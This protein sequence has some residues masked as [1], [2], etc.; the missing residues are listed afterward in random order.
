MNNYSTA[1]SDILVII[2]MHRSGSSLTASLL[3][4]AGL[5]IGRKLLGPHSANIKGYFENIDFF[6]FHKAVLR[7]QAII[8]DGWTLQGKINVED[9]FVE[10]AKEI[11]AKNSMSRVWGWKEPRTT[12]FLDFWSDLLPEAKFLLIYRSPW[13]VVDSLYRRGDRTFQDQPELALKV[14]HQYNQIIIDFYD[15]FS[16]RCLLANIN[17]IVNFKDSYIKAINQKFKTNL[18][19]PESTVYDPSLFHAQPLDSYRPSLVN[20][21]CPEAVEMYQELDARAWWPDETPNFS[22]RELIKPVYKAEAFQEWVNT[23]NQERENKALRVQLENF[24]SQLHQTQGELENSQT[25]LNQIQGELESSQTQLHQTQGEFTYSKSQLHQT[26]TQ[27]HQTQGELH[28]T[29]VEFKRSQSQLH[30]TQRE[31]ENSQTQLH[32]TQTELENSQTQLHQTQEEFAYLKSQLHQTQGE[33]HQTQG[34]LHQ[35]QVE[36][37]RSQSQLHQTQGELE[38]SQTQLHQ[39]QTE[40]ENSQTQLHQ[41]QAELENSQTQLHQTQTELKRSQ[42]QLDQT[43]EE[44]AQSHSQVYQSQR[45]LEHSQIQLHETE[46]LLEHSQMQLHQSEALLEQSQTQLHQKQEEWNRLQTQL[47]QI[48][49]KLEQSQTQQHQIEAKVQQFQMQ[50]HQTQEQ[51]QQSQTQLHQTQE[52]LQQ[53]QTQLHQT[54]EQLQ[55]SQTQLHQTQG[56]LE[57]S[58]F[59]QALGNDKDGQYQMQYRLLVWEA[60]RAYHNNALTKMQECLQ[61]SLKYTPFSGTQTVNDWLE[62]LAKFSSEKGCEFDIYSLTNSQEW[63]QLMGRSVRVKPILGRSRFVGQA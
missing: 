31:L 6:E 18:T 44:L 63:K 30:Q 50:L 27:L 38:N 3:Q 54:Q 29:Q 53:S 51:L 58:Q 24:Q 43:Q 32:Q 16:N 1:K 35:T 48:Q 9:R 4:S 41:T 60:C 33:L 13:E 20:H 12:L 17:T 42:S 28:Q 2:S 8:E 49:E 34:E 7:S 46:A 36:F 10:Q 55:Q 57:L 11:V 15:H 62:S 5:H 59:Q 37:K 56:E 61:Q 26:Q 25:Q 47:Y 21:Y 45:E 23:R 52:Q 19:A 22:W 39:T 14:W 40:L